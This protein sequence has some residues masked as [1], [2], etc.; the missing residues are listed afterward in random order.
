MDTIGLIIYIQIIN[1]FINICSMIAVYS[2]E[3]KA[4]LN[5]DINVWF[6]YLF[7]IIDFLLLG[8]LLITMRKIPSMNI[9]W[10]P[11]IKRTVISFIA[12]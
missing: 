12:V 8:F 2:V 3:E 10:D 1:N 9:E 11:L 7:Q 4:N 6:S 5:I